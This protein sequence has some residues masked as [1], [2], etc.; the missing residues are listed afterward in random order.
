[1]HT[2]PLGVI[3]AYALATGLLMIDYPIIARIS[4]LNMRGMSGDKEMRQ[5]TATLA[6]TGLLAGTAAKLVSGLA[7]PG[8]AWAWLLI[9]ILVMCGGAVLRYW[10]IVTLGRF[11]RFEVMVQ[12]EHKVVTGGPYR[13]VRHPSYTG[14]LLIQLGLGIALGNF[15]S[16]AI[17]MSVPV[18]GFLPRI[19][20]EETAL[21]D[22]L[23]AEYR[24][25]AASTKRLIPGLW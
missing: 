1:M 24:T 16:I 9:G 19:Q 3:F 7:L 21:E 18:L 13:F 22:G 17:C 15:L 10:A 2:S 12:D 8:N 23:G 4:Q 6:I 25:Y 20:H 5:I 14:I 11:F